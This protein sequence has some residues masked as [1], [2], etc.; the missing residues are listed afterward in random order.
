MITI[1]GWQ[2]EVNGVWQDCDERGDRRDGLPWPA[3]AALGGM[4]YMLAIERPEDARNFKI[5]M[6]LERKEDR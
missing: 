6:R 4:R 2:R 3:G 5:D 1:E